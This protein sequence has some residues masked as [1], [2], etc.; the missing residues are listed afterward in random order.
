MREKSME[1]ENESRSKGTFKEFTVKREKDVRVKM[2]D[3][4]HLAVDIYR[5]DA[6]GKFPALLAMSPYGKELMEMVRWLPSSARTEPLW[7]GCIEAGDIDY[8]VSHGYAHIIVD[9]RG[10]GASEGVFGFHLADNPDNYDLVEWLAVQPWCNGNVGTVG[11]SWFGANSMN[12][13]IAAPPHLKAVFPQ[14]FGTDLYRHVFYHGGILCLFFLYLYYGIEGDSGWALSATSRQAFYQALQDPN[15]KHAIQERLKDP[16][17]RNYPNLYHILNYPE[18]CPFF[19]FNM[20]NP[21]DGPFYQEYTFYKL[22]DRIKCPVYLVGNWENEIYTWGTF[23]AWEG[24]KNVPKKMMITPAGF[25]R[26]PY[27]EYHD[28]MLRWYDHHLKGIDT[29]IMNQPPIKLFIMGSN[30]WRFENEWP[31][32]R[33]KW[34]KLYLRDHGRLTTELERLSTASPDGFVQPPVTVTSRIESLSYRTDPL[35]R[36][37]EITGPIALHLYASIDQ[38]DTNWF[39]RFNDIDPLGKRVPLSRGY[40]KAS[41][42]ELDA[43]QSKPWQPYHPHMKAEAVRPGEIYEYAIELMPNAN[44]FKAGHCME[45]EIRSTESPKDP[46][47]TESFIGGNH[48]PVARTVAHT[49]YHDKNH[50]SYLLLPVIGDAQF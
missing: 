27:Q 10:T 16:D 17:I 30:E 46:L 38:D 8:L 5:P 25:L 47:Y 39:I 34:R 14:E 40:L 21:F 7:D 22:F 20:L 50:P 31:L 2:R 26:R 28:E 44:T 43:K 33:T 49:I 32:A 23:Q 36:D 3:G 6:P 41:H 13:A 45:L 42:R 12:A 18:K 48:L 1:K 4:I 29:G 19:V 11:V 24:I 37:V 9:C 35:A 15:V